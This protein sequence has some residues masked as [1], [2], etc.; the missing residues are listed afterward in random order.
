MVEASLAISASPYTLT[1]ALIGVVY[2]ARGLTGIAAT[3]VGG[4]LSDASAAAEPDV[5]QARLRRS[6][7]ASSALMLPGLL[8]FGWTLHHGLH[9][10][11]VIAGLVGFIA[12][13]GVLIPGIMAYVTTVKQSCAG[14]AT[15]AVQVIIFLGAGIAVLTSSWAV[16]TIGS[17]WSFTVMAALNAAV[18]MLAHACVEGASRKHRQSLQTPQS[19]V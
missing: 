12:G 14:A 15:G 4:R 3:L 2:I 13:A 16:Q 6:I 17:G 11:A 9:L 19:L 7:I 1:P 5:P 18:A 10:A 8:L